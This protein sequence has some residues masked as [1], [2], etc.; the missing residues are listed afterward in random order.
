MTA[1]FGLR[2]AEV[3]RG[4]EKEGRD[5]APYMSPNVTGDHTKGSYSKKP[6]VIYLV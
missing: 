1:V 5:G 4:G 3:E 6:T 2:T